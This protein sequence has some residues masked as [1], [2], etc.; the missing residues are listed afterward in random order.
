MNSA[1]RYRRLIHPTLSTLLPA[2]FFIPFAAIVADLVHSSIPGLPAATFVCLGSGL[3]AAGF[4]NLAAEERVRAPGR[5]RFVLVLIALCYLI[6][7]LFRGG[8]IRLRILPGFENVWFSV[9]GGIQWLFATS[10]QETFRAREFLLEETEGK[11]GNALVIAIRDATS[12]TGTALSGLAM[13]RIAAVVF[14]LTLAVVLITLDIFDV[15]IGLWTTAVALASFLFL[16]L[17]GALTSQYAFE[18]DAACEGFPV[19]ERLRS[20]KLRAAL[21][22]IAIPFALAP[23]VCGSSPPLPPELIERFL[24]WLS[25]FFQFKPMNI[26]LTPE[27][28]PTMARLMEELA[29]LRRADGRA[30]LFDFAR[31]FA[32]LKRFFFIAAIVA[33]IAFLLAP[34]LSKKARITLKKRSFRAFLLRK[35]RELASLF[36]FIRHKKEARVRVSVDDLA[37][38]RAALAELARGRKTR[39]KRREVGRM[40]RSFLALIAWGTDRTVP[41]T[42]TTAP[43]E[44]ARSLISIETS[45]EADF[46]LAGD[47]FE[48]A[49]YSDHLLEATR[50]A[51]YEA[52]IGR[53]IRFKVER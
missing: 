48:E 34:L 24:A 17:V 11:E 4:E 18:H 19:D 29:R 25:G 47:I 8:P 32:I 13:I 41:Y 20:R 36:R 23:I 45:L 2:S 27:E 52:A 9:V 3:L 33:V 16:P 38:V 40:T 22:I 50:V 5:F 7:S 42:P 28:D 46:R 44:Y 53:I 6:V 43:G 35:L 49:L 14:S 31:L 15:R 12:L 1:D 26:E 51:A 30:P 10:F 39:Q 37:P 21:L